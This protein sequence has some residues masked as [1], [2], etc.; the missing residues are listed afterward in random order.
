[1][2]LGDEAGRGGGGRYGL[3]SGR[4]APRWRRLLRNAFVAAISL[5]VV[6]FLALY[7]LSR[8]EV[9]LRAFVGEL[10]PRSGPTALVHGRVVEAD[11]DG[12]SGATL[13]VA[14]R[15]AA[16][17]TA[18]SGERG[19]F[20]LE[21]RGRCATYRLELAARVDGRSVDH[22]LLH[23]LCPGQ[24]LELVGRVVATGNFVWVPTR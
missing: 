6:A 24:A 8:P 21:V 7:A 14:A 18:R 12:V 15:G 22:R 9:K 23:R 2:K 4:P 10:E 5:G 1:M 11:G 13:K 17:Q 3:A 16:E 20:S 19:F